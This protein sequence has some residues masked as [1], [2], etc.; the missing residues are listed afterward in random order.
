MNFRTAQDN[1]GITGGKVR[2]TPGGNAGMDA[3]SESGKGRES[4]QRM[5]S[6]QKS[7]V[8]TVLPKGGKLEH[9]FFKSFSEGIYSFLTYIC[10]DFSLYV[11]IHPTHSSS[12]QFKPHL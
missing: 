11:F 7:K 3:A 1:H 2:W 5:L 8:K 9:S 6:V 4:R 12:N 10:L